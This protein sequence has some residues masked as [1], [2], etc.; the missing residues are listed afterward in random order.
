MENLQSIN[1]G[2]WY[3]ISTYVLSNPEK[4]LLN[5]KIVEDEEAKALLISEINSKVKK[6]LTTTKAKEFVLVYNSIKP[7]LEENDVY[8]L[9]SCDISKTDKLSGVLNCRINGEHKQ[10]RF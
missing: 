9:I 2:V 6:Q 1:E 10:I 4:E 3:S 8:E 7:T 5:S